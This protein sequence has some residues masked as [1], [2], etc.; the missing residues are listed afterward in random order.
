MS[1]S[2]PYPPFTSAEYAMTMGV[3]PLAE[4]AIIE[5]DPRHMA[6]ELAL[7]EA[8]LAED[9]AS[10]VAAPA[11]TLDLQWDMLA[12]LLPG[13]AARH[14]AR[15]T[16]ERAGDRW[17]WW[18]HD[19]ARAWMF[20]FGDQTTLPMSPLEWLGRQIQE[21]LLLLSPQPGAP[22]V[23]GMLCFPN[24]WSIA[25][26]LGKPLLAVHHEVPALAEQI[27]HPMTRLAHMLK[28]GRPIWRLNWA[29]K[30]LAR[31]DLLPRADPDVRRAI[32]ALT[33]ENI[34]QRCVMRVERQ[35]LARLPATH[36]I[37]FTIHTYQTPIADFIQ[38]PE[39]ARFLRGTLATTPPE[40][41]AYKGIVP[42]AERLM[43]YLHAHDGTRGMP[44]QSHEKTEDPSDV[45]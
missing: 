23:A 8:L 7:K 32:A 3:R 21:D 15:F 29:I 40:M 33:P 18:N 12:L 28:A 36:G 10:Y 30:P 14:P 27:G 25:E 4:D 41:L 34:G 31:L 16:L 42:F 19:A 2:L 20:R 13:M 26:K 38:N 45:K 9:R 22:L 1:V 37:L 39:Q 6:A 44:E 35:A 5:C 24:A 43:G 11:E 17:L